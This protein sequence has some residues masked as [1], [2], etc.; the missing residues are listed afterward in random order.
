[1]VEAIARAGGRGVRS[2]VGHAFI[3]TRM[4]EEDAVFAGELSGH[5][6]YRDMGFTDNG[7]LTLIQVANIIAARGRPLSEL[8][9]PL[10]RYPSTGEINL[11]VR[12]PDVVLAALAAR[13]G[14]ADLD[15]LDGLTV[16]YPAWWFNIRRSH[17]EPVV[18]LN[19][20]AD[21]A[22]LM[23]EKRQEVLGVIREADPGA[24]VV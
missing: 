4:R 17:T 3:K 8:V 16:G 23:D 20:E 6:Y 19:L 21:T 18:R 1:M 5:Y 14:N 9:G 12:E 22:S 11:R 10:D 2:R 13:Y 15:Y 7:L 24:K